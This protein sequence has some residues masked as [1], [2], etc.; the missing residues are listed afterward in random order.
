M[1]TFW[2]AIIASLVAAYPGSELLGPYQEGQPWPFICTLG[3][4]GPGVYAWGW[5]D[6]PDRWDPEPI[7][8]TCD[9]AARDAVT[10]QCEYLNYHG[11]VTD[12]PFC[13]CEL[14]EGAPYPPTHCL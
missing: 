7:E 12:E 11:G 5:S 2:A 14:F 13:A 6:M 8:D 9:R 10:F 1:G 3:V 4:E